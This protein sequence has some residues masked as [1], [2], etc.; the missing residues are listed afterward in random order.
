MGWK[1]DKNLGPWDFI[2]QPSKWGYLNNPRWMTIPQLPVNYD[3]REDEEPQIW[4]PNNIRYLDDESD[5]HLP[6]GH[7][8][9]VPGLPSPEEDI[10]LIN[11]YPLFGGSPG[12]GDK[13]K[14]RTKDLVLKGIAGTR[15]CDP[16]ELRCP[17]GVTVDD[18]YVYLC[19]V[20]CNHVV[21]LLKS[22]LSEILRVDFTNCC[23]HTNGKVVWVG[24]FA[25]V[26]E[27]NPGNLTSIRTL[28]EGLGG[29]AIYDL[30]SDGQYLYVGSFTCGRLHIYDVNTLAFVGTLGRFSE[31]LIGAI[32]IWADGTNIFV[33]DYSSC[34]YLTHK[35]TEAGWVIS[36]SSEVSRTQ[37][38][39][40]FG[41]YLYSVS[42]TLDSMEVRNLSD[43]SLV[44]TESG[45]FSTPTGVWV[46]GTYIYV[47]NDFYVVALDIA[48]YA[49]VMENG[50]RTGVVRT[51]NN[52]YDYCL[53]IT[54]DGT[55]VYIFDQG[56]NRVIKRLKSNFNYVDE[57]ADPGYA[58]IVWAHSITCDG[59]YVYVSDR[60]LS[61]IHR[62]NKATMNYV[63][64]FGGGELFLP[65]QIHATGGYL[66]VSD[67]GS[68]HSYVKIFDLATLLATDTSPEKYGDPNYWLDFLVGVDL[69]EDNIYIAVVVDDV[70]YI[71]I[72]NRS[73][74]LYVDEFIVDTTVMNIAVDEDYI[75]V[76]FWGSPNGFCRRYDKATYT[77]LNE[78]AEEYGVGIDTYYY[79]NKT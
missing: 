35:I 32:G 15:G 22:N 43:L 9:K 12:H 60:S 27:L 52:G 61:V 16:G 67:L 6:C 29:Q 78:V 49:L 11:G 21:K 18:V 75:F 33:Y 41:A 10:Y 38:L 8:H 59:T 40:G 36:T 51:G 58:T 68:T 76:M 1:D 56:N 7:W 47:C 24:R 31:M 34:T 46:D 70:G 25:N 14:K 30:T 37:S 71:K 74:R 69:D 19:S 53:D 39:F 23:I 5:E 4:T 26:L 50:D 45:E 55:W 65:Y 66:Y 73:S 42:D 63:D 17:F 77:L 13:L 64:S 3:G 72:F 44:T 28:T 2:E 57:Y 62:I 79:A 20:T 54:G 48:T